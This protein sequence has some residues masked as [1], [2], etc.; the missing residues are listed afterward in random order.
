MGRF[1]RLRDDAE[2]RLLAAKGQLDK[3]KY[4]N[5]GPELIA[6]IEAEIVAAQSILEG[7]DRG[8]FPD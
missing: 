3:A 5:A 7:Y 1:N 6:Q 8:E 2:T 4:D